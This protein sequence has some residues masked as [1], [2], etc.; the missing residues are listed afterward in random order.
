MTN[1]LDRV[2]RGSSSALSSKFHPES[3]RGFFALRLASKLHDAAAVRHYVGLL[4]RYSDEQLLVAYRRATAGDTDSDPARRFHVELERLGNRQVNGVSHGRIA[5]IRIER[6][7]VAVAIFIGDRL[8]YPPLVRQLSSDPVKA[9]GSAANFIHRLRDKCPFTMAALEVL[10][11]RREVQR[12]QLAKIITGVL[13]ERQVGVWQV[14]KPELLA[15]FGQPPLRFRKQVREVVSAIWPDIDGGFGA[16][17]IKDALA[18][19]LYCQT[20]HLFDS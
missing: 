7:A 1:I 9:L 13:T 2:A 14:A 11:E 18:L 5:A 8:E 12:S 3:P 15:A 6:R 4:E 20:E 19:G 16:L 17:L 10:P